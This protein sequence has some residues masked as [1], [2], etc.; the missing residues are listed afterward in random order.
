[1]KRQKVKIILILGLAIGA[2]L[3]LPSPF[4]S[5]NRQNQLHE[6]QVIGYRTAGSNDPVA[7]LQSRINSGEAHLEYSEKNGYLES[8]LKLWKVP[9]SSQGL[10]F[11]KTSFQL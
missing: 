7:R 9:T 11:S 3:A 8:V 2:Y 10:V 1:M 6:S 5:A 4:T